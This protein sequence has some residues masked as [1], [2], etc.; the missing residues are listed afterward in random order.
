MIPAGRI[1]ILE[2]EVIDQIAAGEVVER[3]ASVVKELVEN[4]LDAGARTISVEVERGGK[5]AI[6]VI[7]DGCG[8]TAGEAR[9]ALQRHAT[10][11]IT[12][13]DDL[14]ALATMGFRGEAL[15]SI[16]AVSKMTL[17]TR[18][19]ADDAATRLTIDGG[20]VVDVSEVGAPVGT[21]IEV[22]DLLHNVPARLKFLKGDATETSHITDSVSKLA[23]AHPDVHIR[24]RSS[25][26][27]SI[28]APPHKDGFE[29][30]RC[31][32]GSRLG[33]RLHRAAGEENGVRVEAFLAAP[34]LAQSTSRGL[35]LYVGRRAVRD[36]GLLHA[37]VMGYGELVPRGRY[38]VAVVFVDVP[39]PDL[40]VNV[41]PQKLEVRFSDPQ[42][43]YSA[44]RHAVSRAVAD[45]P[46]LEERVA[47]GS[48]PV[49]ME[50]I[51]SHAPP[52]RASDVARSYAAQRERTLLPFGGRGS[53]QSWKLPPPVTRGERRTAPRAAAE[54]PPAEAVPVPAQRFFSSL[55]YLGQ[56]DKT[57]LLCET[58][59]ELVLID[60]H[61]AHE[62]VEFQR[63]RERYSAHAVPVQRLLFPHR[64]ELAAD[65]AEVVGDAAEALAAV[66]FELEPFGGT[67]FAIKAVPAGVR[68][69][70]AEAV[71]RQLVSELTEH[72]GSRAVDE[73][74]DQVFATIACHSVVRAGDVLS[75][76]EA[77]AL[78]ASMDGVDY[79]AHCP[80]GRPVLLRISI[81]EIARRFGRT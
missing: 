74:I 65:E 19:R 15:P 56:L 8:M 1:A 69:D 5:A 36:R 66:G 67:S 32:L 3:P 64:L 70:E 6:C 2:N 27:K 60:Q 17:T 12:R 26:R 68:G 16:A 75:A 38:P 23:M 59:G 52:P 25:G 71:L 42:L 11:K 24:L 10:S 18:T 78:L 58:A 80:H 76:R 43:V 39:S 9:L 35:Q 37:V 20:R 72:G 53:G 54:V 7:D 28:D 40:D 48:A 41:H 57:Y 13:L 63:L 44:V 46:W 55:R 33:G 29:R 31:L 49:R 73:R 62:R 22:R 61:A 81:A 47:V 51:A 4:A 50:A 79:K 21:R 34:E 77:E 45:A 30:A 14:M